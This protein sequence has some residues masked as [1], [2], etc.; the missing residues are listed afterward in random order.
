MAILYQATLTPTKLA[1]VDTWL[2]AQPWTGG[3][4]EPSEL[5][6]NFRFD[7]PAGEVGIETLLLRL[8][9]GRTVQVPL[10]YRG[11]ALEGAGAALIGTLAHSVLGERWVY[12]GCF[13]PVYA[14]ALANAI[15]TGGTEATLEVITDDGIV[16]REPTVRVTGSG[17]AEAAAAPIDELTATTDQT[18]TTI[19]TADLELVVCRVPVGAR[20]TGDASTLTGVWSGADAPVLLALARAR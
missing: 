16:L 4:A 3:A 15:V 20:D 17:T 8:A 12:D 10:T 2:P 19:H 13:D 5:V 1:L 6:G 14:T 7:D 18:A 9:H 11:A